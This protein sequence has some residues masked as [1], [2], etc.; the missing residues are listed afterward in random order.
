[1]TN[2]LPISRDL[3]LSEVHSCKIILEKWE[4]VLTKTDVLGFPCIDY[5]AQASEFLD[6]IS[7]MKAEL[8]LCAVKCEGLAEALQLTIQ[9]RTD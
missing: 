3:M 7:E 6:C 4:K 2:K 9:N 5:A 1:M 8:I